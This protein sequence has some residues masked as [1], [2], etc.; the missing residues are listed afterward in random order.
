MNNMK[1]DLC[2]DDVLIAPQFSYVKSRKDVDVSEEFCGDL[3]NLPIISSNMD[4]V[5]GVKMVHAMREY[6]AQ[7]ALHR[8]QS[9]EENVKQF[10]ECSDDFFKPIVSIGIGKKELERA[11]ALSSIG[12]D[13]F[14]IDVAHGASMHVVEQVWELYELLK[15]NEKVIVGNFASARTIRDFN[16]HLSGKVDAYKVGIGGGS[17]CLTRVVTGCGGNT[18]GSVLDCA[19]LGFPIIADGGIRNS[20][21][22]AKALG[23]GATTVMIGR[24]FA[25]CDESPGELIATYKG[26]MKKYRGSAST[27]SYEVQGKVASHRSYEGDSYLIPYTGPVRDVLQ[28]FEGG[29]RSALSYVGANNLREFREDIEFV[30]I[31]GQG[32]K[33]NGAHG[34]NNG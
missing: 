14:L 20:G 13:K 16:H 10:R 29:L 12:A 15:N 27:E 19:S 6:G 31:T 18:F 17:A 1:L 21:D 28:Q 8:F 4:T 25:G 2:F 34:K 30:Q 5:T 33:E 3:L 26:E 11:E 24:L 23:A 9:I 22:I 32:A 7:A